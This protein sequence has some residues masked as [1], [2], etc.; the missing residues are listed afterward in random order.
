MVT[1]FQ[2]A[3]GVQNPDCTVT[4]FEDSTY[5]S[6]AELQAQRY[7]SKYFSYRA[8]RVPSFST[9]RWYA[10]YRSLAACFTAAAQTGE[11]KR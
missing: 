2:I 10:Q 3:F 4:M 7:P 11:F 1:L 9:C 6:I 8:R 5:R